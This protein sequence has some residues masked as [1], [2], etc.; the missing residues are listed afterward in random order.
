MKCFLGDLKR[1]ADAGEIDPA[2]ECRYDAA[3]RYYRSFCQQR[4]IA[5]SYPHPS[6][7]NR[8]FRLQFAAFLS[9]CQVSPNGRTEAVSMPMKGQGFVLDTVRA[10]FEWAADPERGN[11]LPDGFRNPFHRSIPSPDTRPDRRFPHP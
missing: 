8:E 7:V 2:T 11:L 9:Q 10:L 3:L 4:T 5:K 6:G 1:R